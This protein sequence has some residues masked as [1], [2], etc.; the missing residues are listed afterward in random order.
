TVWVYTPAVTSPTKVQESCQRQKMALVGLHI[1]H[2]TASAPQ[3]IWSTFEHVDNAPQLDDVSAKRLRARY[4]FFDAACTS[5]SCAT[6]IN[7]KPPRP[8]NP[9]VQPFP[10]HFRSQI[11][12][13]LGVTKEVTDMNAGFQGL[14]GKSVWSHY[15]LLSTQWPTDPTSTRD[16]NGAPAPSYLANT[17]METYIQGKT[18]ESS[19][20][21]IKCH[22][23]AV[24][25]A[26]H[27]SDF[28]YILE[29]AHSKNAGAG[30]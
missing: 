7:A 19:S 1:V 24:D 25:T 20:S 23:V 14:L 30:K 16:P 8:W 28:T 3:W 18:P 22:G 13:V 17:T 9:N 6:T 29:R 15:M 2:K 10:N 5:A 21:C 26:A 27:K 4:N 12:R 11:A